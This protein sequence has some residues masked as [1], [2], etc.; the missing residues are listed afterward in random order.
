V[1]SDSDLGL[2]WEQTL[3]AHLLMREARGAI[4]A[5]PAGKSPE[6]AEFFGDD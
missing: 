5:V 3:L 4:Q 2:A 1:V 6:D